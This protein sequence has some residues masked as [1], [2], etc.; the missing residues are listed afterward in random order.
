MRRFL[1][2]G[3][4]RR[5]HRRHLPPPPRTIR[6]LTFSAAFGPGGAENLPLLQCTRPWKLGSPP[7]GV[8]RAEDCCGEP[9]GR[10]REAPGRP[11]GGPREAPGRPWEGPK[12]AYVCHFRA[13]STV[14]GEWRLKTTQDGLKTI[15]NDLK[16]L[17]IASR[18]PS[19]A[20]EGRPGGLQGTPGGQPGAPGR[21]PGGP[22]GRSERSRAMCFGEGTMK[23]F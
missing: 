8:R 19:W 14:E 5:P 17:K 6:F 11:P 7:A 23:F 3:G 1:K 21:P 16:S 10:P 15:E 13:L 18:G 4:L 20:P 12:V 9:A 22:G 2:A